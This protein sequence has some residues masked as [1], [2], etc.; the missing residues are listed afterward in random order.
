MSHLW[1]ERHKSLLEK[2]A[3][4]CEYGSNYNRSV[5]V[6]AGDLRQAIEREMPLKMVLAVADVLIIR[7]ERAR[8][9]RP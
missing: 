6:A 4:Y 2:A 3:P 1:K 8:E 5:A 9:V 7:L